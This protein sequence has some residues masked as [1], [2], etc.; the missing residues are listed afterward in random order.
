MIGEASAVGEIADDQRLGDRLGHLDVQ[1]VGP[2]RVLDLVATRAR[3]RAEVV[4]GRS[5]RARRRGIWI[6]TAVGEHG[7]SVSSEARRTSVS[8]SNAAAVQTSRAP[9]FMRSESIRNVLARRSSTRLRHTVPCWLRRVDS[10]AKLASQKK[11]ALKRDPSSQWPSQPGSKTDLTPVGGI[12]LSPTTQEQSTCRR[13]QR[14]AIARKP[15]G[16]SFEARS[17][18]LPTPMDRGH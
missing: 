5:G 2:L 17:S 9:R 18:E 14:S 10:R 1:R 8:R 16:F 3:L 11:G 6:L 13:C 12:K 15:E 7:G 4:V